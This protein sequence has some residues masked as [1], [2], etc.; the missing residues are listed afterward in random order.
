MA[1][2]DWMYGIIFE[3]RSPLF[4][5]GAAATLCEF[6]GN[7]GQYPS[8]R[9]KDM[10]VKRTVDLLSSRHRLSSLPPLSPP[11]LSLP[12]LPPSPP[13]LLALAVVVAATAAPSPP[14]LWPP[15]P[16]LSIALPRTLS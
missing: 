6:F 4:P 10:L 1:D 16:P 9:E 7:S 5:P 15:P 12:S 13:T 11:P 8:D 14:R 2:L 3:A